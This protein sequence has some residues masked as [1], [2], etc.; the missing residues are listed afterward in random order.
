M[1]FN[2]DFIH[3]SDKVDQLGGQSH[4][5]GSDF[6]PEARTYESL[7][8]KAPE[9]DELLTEVN[10]TV[11][12]TT[13][14]EVIEVDNGVGIDDDVAT[15]D[16]ELEEGEDLGGRISGSADYE[17][18]L[19]DS[20]EDGES[21]AP[22]SVVGSFLEFLREANDRHPIEGL[23]I[24]DRQPE[25]TGWDSTWDSVMTDNRIATLAKSDHLE[26]VVN[27]VWYHAAT[28][29]TPIFGD[30]ADK[31]VPQIS[32]NSVGGKDPRPFYIIPKAN[33]QFGA[34]PDEV[35]DVI[36]VLG[37]GLFPHSLITKLKDTGV[38]YAPR[39]GCSILAG[40]V[41]ILRDSSVGIVV[42]SAVVYTQGTPQPFFCTAQ[43]TTTFALVAEVGTVKLG[44]GIDVPPVIDIMAADSKK[45]IKM[46]LVP[47]SVFFEKWSEPT[48]V[49][50]GLITVCNVIKA[51]A[52]KAGVEFLEKK[53]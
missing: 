43:G 48:G 26:S 10:E 34:V 37:V 3:P 8:S 1:S 50:S 32:G 21:E 17:H 9:E 14:N 42:A 52:F 35:A 40:E 33:I 25:F 41:R 22:V 4:N 16:D 31:T 45:D 38:R 18:I 19:N 13:A 47:H 30:S 7:L 6:T 28:S 49:K 53:T 15:D 2:A 5:D 51:R 39:H 20:S 44:G 29:L 27:K 11:P 12:I 46:F 23:N 24:G 36:I